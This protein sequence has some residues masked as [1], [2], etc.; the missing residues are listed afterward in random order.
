MIFKCSNAP[1]ILYATSNAVYYICSHHSHRINVMI[2]SCCWHN[3]LDSPLH[4]N[5]I[6]ICI[7]IFI[8]SIFIRSM[9][10]DGKIHLHHLFSRSCYWF[11]ALIEIY[12]WFTTNCSSILTNMIIII[13]TVEVPVYEYEW[14]REWTRTSKVLVWFIFN[15]CHTRKLKLH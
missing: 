7:S 10:A 14:D 9:F 3:S 13:I 8:L 5:S 15:E 2:S 11:E 1:N 12:D 4:F 6:S